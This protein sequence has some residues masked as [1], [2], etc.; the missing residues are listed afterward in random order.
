MEF[1]AE[2]GIT[3]LNAPDLGTRIS[4]AY[5]IQ[6]VPE[7]F[8]IDQNGQVQQFLFSRVTADYLRGLIDPL[9]ENGGA[10]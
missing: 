7:T 3:Y 8:I 5:H 9:L 6:G 1:L 2:Y 10:S 4:E